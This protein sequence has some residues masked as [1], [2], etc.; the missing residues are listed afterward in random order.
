MEGRCRNQKN[1]KSKIGIIYNIAFVNTAELHLSYIAFALILSRAGVIGG[2]G[3]G[4][5]LAAVTP[6]RQ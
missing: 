3:G 2:G 6:P 5:D 4:R 1:G